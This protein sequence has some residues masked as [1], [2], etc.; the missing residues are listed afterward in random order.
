MA[1]DLEILRYPIGKFQSPSTVTDTDIEKWISGIEQ[2]PGELIKVWELL[3]P[4]QKEMSYRQEGWTA[5]QLIHHL[6]DSHMNAYIRFKL[7]LTEDVPVIKP[8]EEAKWAELPDTLICP[9]EVSLHLLTALHLRWTV[10]LRQLK[11][12]DWNRRYF[13]PESKKE[14]DLKTVLALYNWHGEHHLGH[15]K[16]ILV[17]SK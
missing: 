14:F 3:K 11:T 6:P 17:K 16:L 13:H 15:L 5:R 12:E 2:L 1:A 7:A 8:Y 9:P 4:E 10:L